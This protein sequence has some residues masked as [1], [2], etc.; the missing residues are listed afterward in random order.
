MHRALRCAWLPAVLILTAAAPPQA[1]WR[2]LDSPNFIVLGEVGAGELRDIAVEFEGFR[3]TLGRVLNERVTSTAVPTVVLVFRSSASFTPFKPRYQGKPVNVSGLFVPQRDV[4]HIAMVSDGDA[5]GLRIIFH[6]YAHLLISNT[7]QRLPVWLNEGLAEYYST[8]ELQRGGR[9]A[10]IGKV[11]VGHLQRLNSTALIRLPELLAVTHE[12]P[13]YNET[14]RRSVFYSQAWA[15]T[16]MLLRSDRSAQLAIYLAQLS[17]GAS[18]TDAWQKAFGAQDIARELDIY[19]RR[20]SYSATLYKFT[21]KLATFEGRAVPA[22]PADT[23]A[24]LANFQVQQREYDGAAARLAEAEKIDPGNARA[25]LVRASLAL[26]RLDP[27]AAQTRVRAVGALDDWFL[28]Y[29]A[30]T[31]LAAV[32]EARPTSVTPDDFVTARQFFARARADRP[33]FANALARM[34]G[35]ETFSPS[36]PTAETRAALEKAHALA[37][38]RHE[39]TMLLAQVLARQGQFAE[40]RAVLGPLLAPTNPPQ[41]R[42]TARRV[43]GTVVEREARLTQAAVP[44]SGAAAPGGATSRPSANAPASSPGITLVFRELKPGEQRFEGTLE[45]VECIAGSGVTFH[46]RSG[47]EVVRVTSP[48]FTG[49]EFLV[50]RDDL[51]GNVQCGPV[52][53]PAPVYMTWKAG[54]S[55]GAKVAVALEFLPIKR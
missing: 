4:N 6:E 34:A 11:I 33:E 21:D 13:L 39:Y 10:I 40:A 48:S 30:G 53:P 22:P 36:G 46:V 20:A 41:I 38:G 25:N 45:R 42:E 54:A 5:D 51:K 37:P 7:G 47:Q 44:V 9:E 49:I 52:T 8:F 28:N 14:D 1:Q 16:H 24:F 27:A 29:V 2:R 31:T 18:P 26:A 50:Y 19:V 23:Q 43:M 17:A 12:S 55:A 35:M 32:G 3:E 15:L